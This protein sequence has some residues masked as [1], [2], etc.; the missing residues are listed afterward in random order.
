MKNVQRRIES[1]DL[2]EI[3][4]T[5][6]MIKAL[7]DTI[8]TCPEHGKEVTIRER[9]ILPHQG[10]GVP[11]AEV[12]WEGC[13]DNAI[14]QVIEGV[15]KMQEAIDRAKQIY[16]DELARKLEPDHT[17]EIVAIEL[18]TNNY[19]IGRNEVDAAHKARSA[20]HEGALYF[21]RVG[22]PYAHRL[23]TPHQ[24]WI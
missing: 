6:E 11:F 19:F 24:S 5:R 15:R 23:M 3:P 16:R 8:R 13:C 18:G 9:E 10:G 1:T 21:L 7:S 20:G 4:R 22:S 2:G 14:D 17:G 12:N